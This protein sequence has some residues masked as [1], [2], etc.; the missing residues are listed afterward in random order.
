VVLCGQMP[1]IADVP[2]GGKR[3]RVNGAV[4]LTELNRAK[5]FGEQC[6]FDHMEKNGWV[7]IAEG[8]VSESNRAVPAQSSLCAEPVHVMHHT[9][10]R[11]RLTL[12]SHAGLRDNI[13]RN[14]WS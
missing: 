2:G 10:H 4:K 14:R 9:Q 8:A 13:D 3:F 5:L 11:T 6:V 7:A 12:L 1:P